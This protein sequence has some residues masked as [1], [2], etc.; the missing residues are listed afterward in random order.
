MRS[1][2]GCGSRP[3]KLIGLGCRSEGD[4]R[5]VLVVDDEARLRELA[6]RM[7]SE[8]GWIVEP[9]SSRLEALALATSKTFALVLSDYAMPHG[10]GLLL[11]SEVGRLQPDCRLVLWSAALPA[12]AARRARELGVNVLSG[13]LLG[14][15]LCAAVDAALAAQ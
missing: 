6:R 9:A 4:Q 8:D 12:S 15:E 5:A 1:N 2:A 13:K 14:D 11:L 3:G 10:D 7:L